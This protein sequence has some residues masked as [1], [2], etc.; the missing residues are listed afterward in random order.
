MIALQ[1]IAVGMIWPDMELFGG[2]AKA[3]PWTNKS[4]GP[5]VKIIGARATDGTGSY[6]PVR[7]TRGPA[8]PGTVIPR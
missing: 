3:D 1:E 4:L 2:S 5:L 6:T 8:P 7:A